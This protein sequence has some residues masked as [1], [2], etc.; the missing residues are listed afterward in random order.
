MVSPKLFLASVV[1]AGTAAVTSPLGGME[2]YAG[3]LALSCFAG[4]FLGGILLSYFW[5][6]FGPW[7]ELESAKQALKTCHENHEEQAKIVLRATAEI[8]EVTARYDMLTEALNRGNFAIH[9]T[10]DPK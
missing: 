4:T 2:Q 7:K 5:K 9:I 3:V 6:T 1:P 10:K 8:A